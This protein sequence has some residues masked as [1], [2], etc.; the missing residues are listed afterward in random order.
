MVI[1][2]EKLK[3]LEIKK[4]FKEYSLLLA[5]DE[6]KK[7]VVSE[8]RSEFLTQIE[9]KKKELGIKPE[10]PKVENIESSDKATETKKT[11]IDLDENTKKKLKKI[12]K[13]IVKKTHPDKIDS[14]RYLEI[15]ITSKKAFEENNIIDLYSICTDLEINFEYDD[16]DIQSMLSII[17]SKKSKLKN[18]ESSYLWLWVHSPNESEKEKIINLFIE[19][20]HKN[21]IS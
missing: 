15:Y 21:V 8:H 9:T 20:H 2:K 18:L 16:T 7:E 4:I 3:K 6:Y 5:D 13:E 10:E 11:I 12:Y 19:T 17:N 14:E 1:M